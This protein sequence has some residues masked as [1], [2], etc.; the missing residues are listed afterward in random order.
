MTTIADLSNEPK[1]TIK[2]VCGFTG[3]R[4]VTL[5]AWERR[6]EILSPYRS[7]NRYRLYSERDIAIIRW[8]KSRVDS[9]ISISNAAKEIHSMSK[10]DI[11]PET[12]EPAIGSAKT[13]S[14]GSPPEKYARNLFDALL[15]HQEA[16][17]TDILRQAQNAFDLKTI[18]T[19]IYIPF[20][21]ELG[22]AWFIGRI[23]IATE[24][25]ASSYIRGRLLSVLQTLPSR[26]NGPLLLIGAAPNE[27]HEIGGLMLAALLREAGLRIEFLGPDLPLDD[28]VEYADEVQPDMVILSATMEENARSLDHAQDKLSHLHNHPMFGF[29]G[30][31]F[32]INPDLIQRTGGVYLGNTLDEAVVR[33]RQTMKKRPEIR[34]HANS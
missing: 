8:I 7:E 30:R 32:T 23:N 11:W 10:N 14:D 4:A 20:L 27:Q 24:H 2:S 9:G 21:T 34:V 16:R 26:R 17:A 22:E 6:H 19:K 13:D 12:S 18:C 3:I 1:Y 25:F 28:L 15:A 33:I 31:A 5:R 29:G